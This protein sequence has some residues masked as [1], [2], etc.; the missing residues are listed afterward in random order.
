MTLL[1]TKSD[2]VTTLPGILQSLLSQR[3]SQVLAVTREDLRDLLTASSHL[4]P[5]L[6]F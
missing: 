1:K 5:I 2:H 6:N 4:H 3:K